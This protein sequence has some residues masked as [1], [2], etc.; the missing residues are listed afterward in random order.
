MDASISI[1]TDILKLTSAE[2]Y[3]TWLLNELLNVNNGVDVNKVNFIGVEGCVV[4][5]IPAFVLWRV[6]PWLEDFF[7]SQ[8]RPDDLYIS[9]PDWPQNTLDAFKQLVCC[10]QFK[11]NGSTSTSFTFSQLS[12]F[13]HNLEQLPIE[14]D[15]VDKNEPGVSVNTTFFNMLE[16]RRC[17]LW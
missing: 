6:F 4:I 9:I 14:G 1:K 12:C 15:N 10:G 11:F 17:I 8:S 3:D 7:S 5:E 13:L 16:D 2:D